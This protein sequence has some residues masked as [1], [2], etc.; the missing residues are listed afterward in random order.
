[1]SAETC[2]VCGMG[3]Y[4][5]AYDP[6]TEEQRCV[7][8]IGFDS[9]PDRELCLCTPAIAGISDGPNVE[10]PTH[11]EVANQQVRESAEGED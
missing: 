2:A 6:Q 4:W 1:M 5:V 11:G 9:Y 7:N 10:C 8:H 3:G